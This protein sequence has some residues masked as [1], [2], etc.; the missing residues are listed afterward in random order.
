[1]SGRDR[2]QA[3]VELALVLPVVCLLLCGVLQVVVVVRDLLVTQLAAREA[4]RAASV[5]ATPAAAA[6]AAVARL[7]AP[8][9][10]AVSVSDD[11][12]TVT[13]T[14][15]MTSRTDVPLV[16]SLLPDVPLTASVTMAAEPP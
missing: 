13:A 8:S 4:A 14:V 10:I 7:G 2:G 11:G 1:V 12:D 5:S 15:G 9:S 3:T 6:A 16:G